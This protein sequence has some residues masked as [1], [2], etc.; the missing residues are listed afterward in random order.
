MLTSDENADKKRRTEVEI[1]IEV[2]VQKLA[3]SFAYMPRKS[4]T[5]DEKEYCHVTRNFGP[6]YDACS[7]I[8]ILGSFPS[9][10][11][12]EAC[13]YYGHPQNRFWPLMADLLNSPV[14]V[15]TE[16]KRHLM[17]N[18][19]IALWDCIESCDILGSSDSSIRNVVP[20]DIQ[21]VLKV[22]DI[23]C[24]FANGATS[25]RIYKRYLEPI[26]GRAIVTLPS[27][28]PANAAW[29]MARLREAWLQIL[30]PLQS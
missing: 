10:R 16:D 18:H 29:N 14:P 13:F 7:R 4:Q 11:S 3:G 9:V 1:E 30:E 5:S 20:V 23:Q 17:L 6:V 27:T 15:Q 2:E 26:T 24:I 25:A 19:A 28:S 8:L 21:K 22:A 12:R